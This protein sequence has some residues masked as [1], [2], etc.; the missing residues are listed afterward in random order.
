MEQLEIQ[1]RGAK[2]LEIH[3]VEGGASLD[4][5]SEYNF[6]NFLLHNSSFCFRDSY[7]GPLLR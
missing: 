5:P 4:K 3:T 7:A 6:E 1:P 2:A